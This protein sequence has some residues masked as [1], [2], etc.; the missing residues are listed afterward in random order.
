MA[1]IGIIG[2]GPGGLMT[3]ELLE[4]RY[5][6]ACTVTIFEASERVGGKLHT[7]SFAHEPVSYEAGAAELYDYSGGGD[8]PLRTLVDDLGLDARPLDGK[9]LVLHGEILRSD[10]DLARRWGE[11][12]L[13]AVRAFRRRAATLLPIE[14]WHPECWRF[15][16]DHPWARRTCEELLQ[17]V[18]D[19]IAREYLR[20]AV[21]S[22]LATE[23]RLTSGLNG[24][25]NLVMD[26]PGY[27]ACRSVEGGM[28]RL[29][30]RLVARAAGAR[31]ELGARVVRVKADGHRYRIS[32]VRGGERGVAEVDAVVCALPLIHLAAVDFAGE[33]LRGRVA[34]HVSRFDRP[35]HYLRVSILFR[36]PFWRDCLEGSWFMLD[37][38]GGTCV[39]DES[40]RFD[41]AERGVLGFLLAGADAFRAAH[42]TD[43][44]LVRD[45]LRALPRTL[46]RDAVRGFIEARVHRWCGGVSGEPGGLPAVDPVV[47]HRP[48]GERFGGLLLVGDYL[49]DSTLNGVHRSASLAC[50]LL[51]IRLLATAA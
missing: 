16:R 25:K 40:A 28:S 26:I 9:T 13:E 46:R 19:E 3:A 14:H 11:S 37:A 7:R 36:E 27:V 48:G 8:D 12:T 31:V 21:H 4:R 38:F 45:A 42:R 10:A 17:T 29:A 15:D 43:E 23:P 20:V 49:F 24:L 39:Y 6:D 32:Y 51:A 2:G 18:D 22:D 5:G 1:R 47:S 41:T 35:G 30:E 50:E 44:Q 33:P 34:A